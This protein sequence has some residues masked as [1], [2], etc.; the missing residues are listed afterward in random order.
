MPLST[1]E[2][3]DASLALINDGKGD[4]LMKGSVDTSTLMKAVLDEGKGI[5]D[6]TG[7][8]GCGAAGVSRRRTTCGWS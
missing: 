7:A 8:L 1:P 3:L 6:R 5:A 2:A 4:V